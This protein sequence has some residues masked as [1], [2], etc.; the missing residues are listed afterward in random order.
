MSR[1]CPKIEPRH[2]VVPYCGEAVDIV[3]GQSA[4]S[5]LPSFAAI[6]GD[7]NRAVKS[8]DEC[9]TALGLR[10]DGADVLVLEQPA[11][12]RPDAADPAF[13]DDD[14]FFGADPYF[15]GTDGDE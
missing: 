3:L 6:G 9:Q 7:L 14:S 12:D 5:R 4:I 13:D 15:V 8:P 2:V 1:L 11:R 10:Q